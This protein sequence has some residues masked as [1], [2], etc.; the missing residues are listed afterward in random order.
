MENRIIAKNGIPIYYYLNPNS[1]GFFISLFFRSGSM[2]ESERDNGITHFLEHIAIRNVNKIMGGE[3]YSTLDK[4]AIEFNASSYSEMVQ[5]YLSG[6][7]ENVN[8][9]IDIISKLLMP[10]SLP[11]E[12]IDAERGRPGAVPRFR[13]ERYYI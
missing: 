12:D 2:Y 9:A 5:F 10:I 13:N 3:L 8:V 6:A 7:S 1:H 4:H 11:R